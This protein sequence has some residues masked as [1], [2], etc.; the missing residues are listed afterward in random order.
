FVDEYQDLNKGQYLLIKSFVTDGELE[1]KLC[2][3]GD[4][5]QSIY[6][7]RG[8]SLYYFQKFLDDY[9]DA[10]K[11]NLTRNYRSTETILAA[12][13]QIIKT[14]SV[15][16]SEKRIHSGIN[17]TPAITIIGADTE[18][19]EAVNVG[20]VIENLIGG[21]G[22]DSLNFAKVDGSSTKESKSFA[23][24][25][26]FYRT[27]IQA[28]VIADTFDKSGIPY[29][30]ADREYFIEHKLVRGL[31]SILKLLEKNGSYTDFKRVLQIFKFGI[32][33]KVYQDFK[34]WG[35]QNNFSIQKSLNNAK[36]FP[37][38]GLSRSAQIKLNDLI[39]HIELMRKDMQAMSVKQK[40]F[41][42]G[43]K[44]ALQT[45]HHQQEE[46]FKKLVQLSEEFEKNVY[47]FLTRLTLQSD[48][49]T[50]DSMTEKVSLMT[51]H[52]AKGLEF[53]V[54]FI[55]GCEKDYIP[56]KT[57]ADKESD[58]DEERRLFYVAMT[59]AKESLYLTYAKRRRVYG[60]NLPRKLSPFVED[61][62]KRLRNHEAPFA[63]RSRKET[64]V[65]LKLF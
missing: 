34:D 27:S 18:K 51:M 57:S 33:E 39:D 1:N 15:N 58:P 17:G 19:A 11:I 2:V 6:G 3:I 32:G 8:S 56:F 24:V 65:Q 44:T 23:D 37:V 60:K 4:P 54:V 20:R 13:H 50:Y 30:I 49:D 52:A 25:A 48:T 64:Q 7:F 63:K 46:S 12:S 42:L 5:N 14:K 45:D 36:R 59:R 47:D 9:P 38:P 29:Q 31:V 35:Y 22:F 21:F 41:Y 55:T 40:L 62:E 10:A 43:D 53:P 26:V 16:P 61:I 28:K